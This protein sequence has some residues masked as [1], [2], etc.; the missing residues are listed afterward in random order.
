MVIVVL[1]YV[2]LAAAEGFRRRIELRHRAGKKPVRRA[3][4]WKSLPNHAEADLV[5]RGLAPTHYKGHASPLAQEPASFLDCPGPSRAGTAQP[6]GGRC[7][8]GGRSIP[9]RV[10]ECA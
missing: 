9:S 3:S 10:P 7:L 5:T 6:S 4:A 2:K 8:R 1:W